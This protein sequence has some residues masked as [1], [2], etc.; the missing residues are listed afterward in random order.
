MLHEKGRVGKCPS[1]F[2]VPLNSAIVGIE[3]AF[4]VL[5][6]LFF[7]VRFKGHGQALEELPALQYILL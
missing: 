1:A 2:F 6:F 5:L 7:R 4:A 3:R